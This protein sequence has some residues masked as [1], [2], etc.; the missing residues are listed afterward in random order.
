GLLVWSIL[1]RSKSPWLAV[2]WWWFLIMLLPVLGLIKVGTHAFADRYTYLPLIGIFIGVAFG[3]DH[4]AGQNK[5]RQRIFT[6]IAAATL[7][8]CI[9]LTRQQLMVWKNSITLFEQALKATKDN[10]IAHYNLASALVAQN[11]ADEA[12]PHYEAV[13]KLRPDREDVHFHMGLTL[14]KL[15]NF[16]AA[17]SHFATAVE[18]NPANSEAR[19]NLGNILY[20]NGKSDEAIEQFRQILRLK[21]AHDG[22]RNNL[23]LILMEQTRL[24]EAEVNFRQALQ[25]RPDNTEAHFNL[26][27]VLV[28]QGQVAEGYHHLLQA[29]QLAPTSPV[30]SLHLAWLLATHPDARYRRG[31]EAVRLATQALQL[32]GGNDAPTLDA[33]AAAYAETGQFELAIKTAKQA[34]LLAQSADAAP[35]VEAL[36]LRLKQ[37]EKGQAWRQQP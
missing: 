3:A 6:G 2:A 29:A 37:Y 28:K 1:Q 30:A 10:P 18:L 16:Q 36:D 4:W 15:Q 19:M 20:L 9:G 24:P 5:S 26:G 25:V 7:I 27:R 33:L 8:A 12:L 32:T 13:F 34:S 17:R 21:P 23:G 11:R 14:V 31:T 35:M 22:A